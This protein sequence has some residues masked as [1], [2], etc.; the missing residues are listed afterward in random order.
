[1]KTPTRVVMP[2]ALSWQESI[3]E[4][5]RLLAAAPHRLLFF[6]GAS[7]IL[8]SMSWWAL[9]LASARFGWNFLVQL[10]A[11]PP[12]WAHAALMQYGTLSMFVFGFLLTVFPR[13]MGQPAL[14]Q[15]RYIPVGAGIF[16]GYILAHIGLLSTRHVFIAGIA[17]MLTG[18][19]AALV[20]LGGLLWR[21]GGKDR[22]A[23]SCFIALS[24]GASGLAAFFA[25]LMGASWLYA[26][27]AIRLGTFGL[28]LPIYFS[29]CHRMVPFFSANVIKNYCV[30]KPNWSL[31]V[32]WVLLL[33]RL[34]I[35]WA[36]R[37]DW[38]W[39]VDVPLMLFFAWHWLAWQPWK[40]RSVRLLWALHVALAWLP[41]AFAL[42]S[43]QSLWQYF[44]GAFILG[45]VPV[46]ALTVGFFGS[47]LVAMV[48]RVTQGHSGR[49]LEMGAL[50]WVCFLALQVV[51]VLRILSELLPDQPFW[52]TIS[53]FAWVVAFLPWVLRS[54]WIYCTPRV[55][56]NS[57]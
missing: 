38:L 24:L 2:P 46:H 10:P 23:L 53:A 55:D 18:W 6:A 36:H 34:A 14:P 21:N 50:A 49:P 52:L 54:A 4:L 26:F 48:T 8:V 9:V 40:A 20:S 13:W 51:A 47:M 22:H 45:R 3:A 27:V 35:E 31:P 30:V 12:G 41:I 16:G 19:L 1:M 5:P 56:G 7:A 43:L 11:I 32:L 15:R 57:G 28:L 37:Y 33:M 25:W 39:I 44:G 42:F 17:L 29:V